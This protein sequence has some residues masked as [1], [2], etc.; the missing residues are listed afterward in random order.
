MMSQAPHS[1]T[2]KH[3]SAVGHL[4]TENTKAQFVADIQGVSVSGIAVFL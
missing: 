3:C 4:K 1:H 2:K